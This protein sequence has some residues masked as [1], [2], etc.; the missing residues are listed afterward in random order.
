MKT[1]LLTI[2]CTGLLISAACPGQDMSKEEFTDED[3]E[4]FFGL[5][6]NGKISLEKM[7]VR[8]EKEVVGFTFAGLD[9]VHTRDRERVNYN[10]TRVTGSVDGRVMRSRHFNVSFGEW[11]GSVF[12]PLCSGM[13]SVTVNFEAS[14]NTQVDLYLRKPG[15]ER[16]GR[17]ILSSR[18]GHLSIT[19]PLGTGDELSTY[20][21]PIGDKPERTIRQATFTAHKLGHID[22]YMAEFD[23]D[24]W[25]AD[26]EALK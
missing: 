9:L 19:L 4:K 8:C 24:A 6:E 10:Q 17:N 2:L 22:K 25:N 26:I 21:I 15:E 5:I 18:N 3:F 16:P 14:P 7:L 11:T 1:C 20:S 12:K 13:W 23:E